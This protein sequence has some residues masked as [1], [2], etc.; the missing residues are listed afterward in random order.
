MQYKAFQAQTDLMAPVRLM[1][2]LAGEGLGLGPS[3]LRTVPPL[4]HLAAGWEMIER[5]GG[6]TFPQIFIGDTYVGGSDELQALA[7]DLDAEIVDG[8]RKAQRF[9]RA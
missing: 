5:S 4:S 7:V 2:K 3:W 8:R 9:S 1:A 6:S